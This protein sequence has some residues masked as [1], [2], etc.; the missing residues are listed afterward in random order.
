MSTLVGHVVKPPRQADETDQ[1]QPHPKLSGHAVACGRV[2]TQQDNYQ[3]IKEDEL[4]A[5]SRIRELGHDVGSDREYS[6]QRYARCR[7][8]EVAPP[9]HDH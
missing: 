7:D 1:Q 2:L 5:N 8:T 9:A 4:K 6:A 3:Q